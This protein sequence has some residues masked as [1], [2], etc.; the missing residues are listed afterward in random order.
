MKT[1]NWLRTTGSTRIA[2]TY[3]YGFDDAIANNQHGD[4]VEVSYNDGTPTVTRVYDRLG[5]PKTVTSDGTTTTLYYD[6]AGNLLKE[7]YGGGLMAGIWVTNGYDH[8]LRRTNA[9]AWYG[10][11]GGLNWSQYTYEPGNRLHSASERLSLTSEGVVA[12]YGYVANSPLVGQVAF[13][14]GSAQVTTTKRYDKLNRLTSTSTGTGSSVV[15]F[16]YDYNNANQRNRVTT[17]DGS[18]WLYEYDALGQVIGGY[19]YWADGTPVSGQQFGYAFDDIGNRNTT[20]VNGRQTTYSAN[21]LNQYLTRSTP[22]AVDVIGVALGNST[23]TVTSP[24]AANNATA[25]YRRGEYFHKTLTYANSASLWESITTTATGETPKSGYQYLP[26]IGESFTY[27]LDGNLRTDNRWTYTWDAENRLVRMVANNYT[28][29]NGGLPK[30]VEYKY[31]WQGRRISKVSWNAWDGSQGSSQVQNIRYVYDE[32]NLLAEVA[33]ANGNVI[34]RY[35]WGTDLSGSMQ[36]AGGVGGLLAVRDSSG[37]HV[38]GY[39]GNGNVAALFG[40]SG[41]SARYE[42]GPFGEVIRATG[43][44]AKANPFRFSTKY[45]DDESDLLYYGVRYLKT[46]TGGWLSRDPI[47][48]KGGLNL[49]GFVRNDPISLFDKLGQNIGIPTCGYGCVPPPT[50]ASPD[51]T[52]CGIFADLLNRWRT[53]YSGLYEIP[54]DAMGRMMERGQNKTDIEQM[55]NLL[56]ARCKQF[57]KRPSNGAMDQIVHDSSTSAGAECEAWY[58]GGHTRVVS[59]FGDCCSGKAQICLEVTD[60]F[61]FDEQD[62][63][64]SGGMQDK[65]KYLGSICTG[66]ILNFPYPTWSYANIPVHGKKCIQVRL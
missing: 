1:R 22:R 14:N 42:Y 56:R 37:A 38:V 34:R 43:P 2:T 27:D 52:D 11:D 40:S 59:G 45:Q 57:N 24:N 58:L 41:E 16:A 28:S 31:D 33:G 9:T 47:G 50:C 30:C 61:D 53:G 10:P 60:K 48:E 17:E 55:K 44:M 6:L 20:K 64:P 65:I 66:A 62:P 12:T 5:Q 32:W 13:V 29:L 7:S 46:S 63:W 23:V 54:D 25:P 8:L 15:S 21:R 3:K 19:K 18:Y 26:P 39:D 36:G 51:S 4:L 49:Y 35:L